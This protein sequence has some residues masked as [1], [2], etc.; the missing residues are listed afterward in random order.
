MKKPEYLIVIFS[1]ICAILSLVLGIRQVSSYT[2]FKRLPPDYERLANLITFEAWQKAERQT[3]RIM[4]LIV[5][6][7]S[8]ELTSK[9]IANFPCEALSKI[10]KTWYQASQGQFSLTKQHQI[11]KQFNQESPQKMRTPYHNSPLSFASVSSLINNSSICS[12]HKAK[13]AIACHESLN[14]A[15]FSRLEKCKI[16]PLTDVIL[17]TKR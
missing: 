17:E 4:L 13:K 11:W 15:I 1:L 10:D 14:L 12:S 7:K 8:Q 9:D 3:Y 16:L 6:K 5:N 2:R